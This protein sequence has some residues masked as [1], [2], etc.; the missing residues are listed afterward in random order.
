MKQDLA[1]EKALETLQ[2][3][4]VEKQ[5][6]CRVLGVFVRPFVLSVGSLMEK[7]R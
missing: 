3:A 6:K 4:A 1:R 5:G 7:G 2:E